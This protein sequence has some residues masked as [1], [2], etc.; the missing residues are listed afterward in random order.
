MR[1]LNDIVYGTS[2]VCMCAFV[3]TTRTYTYSRI[4]TESPLFKRFDNSESESGNRFD[5]FN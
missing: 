5:I 1:F 2:F 3:Y 4:P